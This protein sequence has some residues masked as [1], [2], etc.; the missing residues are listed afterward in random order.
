[1]TKT[2]VVIAVLLL[3]FAAPSQIAT[4]Q[5]GMSKAT[6]KL[7]VADLIDAGLTPSIGQAPGGAYVITVSAKVESAATA[8]QVNTF[9]TNRSVTAKVLTVRF[10]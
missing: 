5:G 10:E 7:L 9:A 4:A 2:R 6:A 3:L 8:A 1:M